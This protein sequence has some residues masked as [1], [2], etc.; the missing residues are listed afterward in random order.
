M[1]VAFF[2]VMDDYHGIVSKQIHPN[3][4]Y[5]RREIRMSIHNL[6]C[7]IQIN[8]FM[9][10]NISVDIE[11]VVL[12]AYSIWGY[13]IC[14]QAWLNP[15]NFQKWFGQWKTI[16]WCRDVRQ[17]QSI[18]RSQFMPTQRHEVH[19]KGLEKIWMWNTQCY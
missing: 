18:N 2:L 14:S 13:E 1:F 10:A 6:C 9:I 11:T 7:L 19:I 16:Q 4:L 8:C 3:A 15:P 12:D 17:T 5:W